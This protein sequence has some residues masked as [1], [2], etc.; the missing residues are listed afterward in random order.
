MA[1]G[2]AVACNV[3]VVHPLNLSMIHGESITFAAAHKDGKEWS[4]MQGTLTRVHS[5]GSRNIWR[6][7]SKDL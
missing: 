3:T 7:W 6:L 2:K 1:K 4:N 5:T